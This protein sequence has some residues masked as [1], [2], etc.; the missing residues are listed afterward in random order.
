MKA[1]TSEL[2]QFYDSIIII[3][4]V[5]QKGSISTDDLHTCGQGSY[6]A[7]K[8]AAQSWLDREKDTPPVNV[9]IHE[10]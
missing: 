3:G 2:G 7:Q 6:Y 5:R 4:T 1:A 8:G 9:H 10:E